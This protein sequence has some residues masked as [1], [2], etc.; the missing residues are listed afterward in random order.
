[1][2]QKNKGK[3]NQFC[4]LLKKKI[5]LEFLKTHK[6]HIKSSWFVAIAVQEHKM[7]RHELVSFLL[8]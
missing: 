5:H 7:V 3:A 2:C 1:V 6:T 4:V 8:T